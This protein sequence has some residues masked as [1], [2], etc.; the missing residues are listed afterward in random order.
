MTR[1]TRDQRELLRVAGQHGDRGVF[2]CDW[3]KDARKLVTLGLCE[4]HDR[5]LRLVVR[6]HEV[7]LKTVDDKVNGRIA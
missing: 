7:L 2:I 5:R 4:W 3:D 1:L 6:K